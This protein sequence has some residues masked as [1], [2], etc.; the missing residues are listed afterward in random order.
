VSG[1]PG[2]P[3]TERARLAELRI[4]AIERQAEA[5]LALDLASQAVPYV[6]QPPL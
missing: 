5:R 6:S 2:E 1:G 4:A 3:W